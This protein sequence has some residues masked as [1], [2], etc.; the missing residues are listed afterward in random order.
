MVGVERIKIVAQC[1]ENMCH[2]SDRI[3]S[4]LY[5]CPVS[6]LGLGSVLLLGPAVGWNPTRGGLYV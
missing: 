3:Y 5:K 6:V 2:S 1:L 4:A